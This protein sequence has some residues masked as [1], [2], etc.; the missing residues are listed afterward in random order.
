MSTGCSALLNTADRSIRSIDIALRR[1][2]EIFECP[3]DPEVLS[4]FY[5][6]DERATTVPGLIEGFAALNSDLAERID[7]HHTIGQSFFMGKDF[8]PSM[9][10]RAWDRQIEPL[11]EDYF[12]D[13]VDGV[14]QFT[15][16]RF[17]PDLPSA[18]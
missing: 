17:W 4:G 3:A 14:S 2:F 13:Q 5:A 16:D 11:I 8:T 18:D 15:L 10:R 12:F 1:R 9:L 6:S 7:R